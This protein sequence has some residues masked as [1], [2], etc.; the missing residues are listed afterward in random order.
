MPLALFGISDDGLNLAVN[1]LVLFLVVIWIALIVW[2]YLD[3][4]RRIEDDVLVLCATAAS[5]FPF[6]GSIIYAILRP[7]E[8]LEDAR[9]RELETRAAELRVRQLSEQACPNCEYPIERSYLRCP[10]CQARLK[11]PCPS[12]SKPLDPRWAMCPYCEAPVQPRA[13][14]RRPAARR[15]RP[16]GERRVP[17]TREKRPAQRTTA[18]PAR[19]ARPTAPRPSA[20]PAPRPAAAERQPARPSEGQPKPRPDDGQPPATP[21]PGEG[22]PRRAP[23]P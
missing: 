9:E 20:R 12:C 5:F 17:V 1:L 16:E 2:T 7:P 23:A 18:R 21:A 22:R 8:F 15:A 11:D 4:R 10:N 6:V 3:A 19:S 13:R 14:E